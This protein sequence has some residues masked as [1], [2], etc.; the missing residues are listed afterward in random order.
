MIFR[1][2]E[3]DAASC[4]RPIFGP[5]FQGYIRIPTDSGRGLTLNN[6][7]LDNNLHGLTAIQ[8]RCIDLNLLS[9]KTPADRKGFKTSLSKPFLLTLNRYAVL[10]RKAVK[11]CE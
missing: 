5:M 4:K 9:G 7:I 3:M 8:T 2:E 11:R 6:A 1:P 10:V